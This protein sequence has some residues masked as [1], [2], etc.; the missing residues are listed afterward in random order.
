MRSSSYLVLPL[1]MA[2]DYFGYAYLLSKYA[3]VVAMM[4]YFLGKYIGQ[5]EF[6]KK[7]KR[8]VIKWLKGKAKIKTQPVF[9]PDGQTTSK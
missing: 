7:S 1:L 9:L 3:V 4:T 5:V 8:W 2:I 6:R